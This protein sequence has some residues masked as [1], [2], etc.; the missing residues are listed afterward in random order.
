MSKSCI[1]GQPVLVRI[2]Q[3]ICATRL[4]DCLWL[5]FTCSVTH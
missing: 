5:S 2:A 3:C 1:N 4:Y